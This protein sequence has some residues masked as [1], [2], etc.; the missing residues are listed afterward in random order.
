MLKCSCYAF[1]FFIFWLRR[2]PFGFAGLPRSRPAASFCFAGWC[3]YHYHL[4]TWCSFTRRRPPWC[5]RLSCLGYVCP[6]PCSVRRPC[7]RRRPASCPPAPAALRLL[8]RPSGTGSAP[9]R[10]ALVA[11]L[12]VRLVVR[13]RTRRRPQRAS[14]GFPAFRHPAARLARPVAGRPPGLVFPACSLLILGEKKCV[15]CVKK[16]HKMFGYFPDFQ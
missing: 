10:L 4:R 5:G 7:I 15:F 14:S 13:G 12:R 2:Q 11:V 16:R 3:A 6:R 8:P 9:P 1:L